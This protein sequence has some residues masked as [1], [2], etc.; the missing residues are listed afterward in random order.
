MEVLFV[1]I[2]PPELLFAPNEIL[3]GLLPPKILLGLL[4]LFAPNEILP[5]LLPPKILVDLLLLFAPNN[6]VAPVFD[7]GFENNPPVVWL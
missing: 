1:K 4:L 2:L 6:D 7:C 5:A 3:V